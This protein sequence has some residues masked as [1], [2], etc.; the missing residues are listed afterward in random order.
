MVKVGPIE[1]LEARLSR[2]FV[3]PGSL[4]VGPGFAVFFRPLI[5]T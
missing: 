1:A 3:K 5:D 2:E 4:L